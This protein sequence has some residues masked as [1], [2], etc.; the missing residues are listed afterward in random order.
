LP[1]RYY[2][3]TATR[4]HCNLE[5]YYKNISIASVI[6]LEVVTPKDERTYKSVD[7]AIRPEGQNKQ[8]Y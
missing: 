2:V 5:Y 3:F 8:L 6:V 7:E 4:Q 1:R